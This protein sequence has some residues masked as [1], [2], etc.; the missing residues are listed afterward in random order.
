MIAKYLSARTRIAFGLACLQLSVLSTAMMIGLVPNVRSAT[1]AGR[2]RLCETVA[3]CSSDYLS[4]NDLSRLENLLKL[5]VERAPDLLSA[6]IREKSGN[7]VAEIGEHAAHWQPHVNDRSTESEFIAPIHAKAGRW[8]SVELRFR[9]LQATGW[10]AWFTQPWIALSIF[11]VGVSY[12]LFFLYLGKMLRHL[13][14][15][16]AVPRR[17][18]AALDSLAEGL[19]VIDRQQRIVL[20]NQSF[21]NWV[22]ISPERLTGYHAGKLPWAANEQGAPVL[23]YPWVQAIEQQ[24][25]LASIMMCLKQASGPVRVLMANASPVLGQDGEYRGVLISFDDVTQ[26]EET[27]RD[28]HLAKK[29][30]EDANQAKSTFLAQMSHEIRTPMN[31]ILGFT[32]I[33]QRGMAKD[34]GQRQNYLQT[35]QSSGEHL[36]TLI[37]DI[38][39]LS[40]IESGKLELELARHSPLAIISQSMTI[41]RLKAQEKDLD[42]AFESETDLPET[43]VTDSVRLRQIIINLVGNA[44]K[45]TQRGGVRVVTRYVDQPRPE[46]QIDIVDTGIG[47]SPE[48]LDKVFDAF[49]QEDSSITRRFGGTGLGLSICRLLAE[50]MRGSVTVTSTLG[51]GSTFRVSL[52]P[53]SMKNIRLVPAN[54]QDKQASPSQNPQNETIYIGPAPI[55]VVD[56]GEANR[57]LASLYLERAGAVVTTAE[58][59]KDALQKI[60]EQDFEVILM[61]VHMPEMDGLTAVRHL[62]SQGYHRPI[63]A[64]TGNVMKNDEEACLAA[65][66]SGFLT[67]PIRMDH[68]L[69]AVAAAI[70][71]RPRAEN[72]LASNDSNPA[73]ELQQ[74][75]DLQQEIA[76]ITKLM[77]S[78]PIDSSLP[79][80]DEELATIV[81]SFVATLRE[82]QPLFQTAF[83]QHDSHELEELAHWLKGAGGSLGFE[84][85]NQPAKLL[86]SYAKARNLQ[87]CGIHLQEIFRLIQRVRSTDEA[88]LAQRV[89]QTSNH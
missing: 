72:P 67:K 58:N 57:K 62:R 12:I 70:E 6:A 53:G 81:N 66:F 56:D 77:D 42:F 36:L 75:A 41:L 64:L 37:N 76:T 39:D 88:A 48:A 83:E 16:K 35:I 44:I 52:D 33:L 5:T 29:S 54:L 59:G 74:L 24:R 34:E 55:L 27:R 3:I 38:L 19:L 25:P 18:R 20:A 49:S 23:E 17:V 89:Y 9:E 86:E 32:E 43:I 84:A 87:E 45:F 8:G 31:A 15:S 40:K 65:G 71:I 30:A 69:S 82:K 46:L 63:I 1:V 85:F 79:T 51:V 14:P 22:Q 47:I 73:D 78:G 2:I 4:R 68:L 13:D 28:L 21:A 60:S 11:V 61:D 80:E 7:I 26:L 10:M 50:K